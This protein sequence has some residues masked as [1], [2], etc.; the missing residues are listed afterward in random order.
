MEPKNKQNKT[1]TH[2]QIEGTD[3]WWL[4]EKEEGRGAGK[5]SERGHL[6]G[7]KW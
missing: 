6:Y 4:P 1:N 3:W 7:E 5:M 2:S